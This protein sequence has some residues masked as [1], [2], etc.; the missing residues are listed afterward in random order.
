MHAK[1]WFDSIL[2]MYKQ[3]HAVHQAAVA[4]DGDSGGN[5]AHTRHHKHAAHM[6]A[7]TAI[8]VRSKEPAQVSALADCPPRRPSLT[9]VPRPLPCQW[10]HPP[11]VQHL[12]RR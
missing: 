7:R 6:C 3:T 1:E 12:C 5:T 4:A 2:V 10:L 9:L 11:H 8:P